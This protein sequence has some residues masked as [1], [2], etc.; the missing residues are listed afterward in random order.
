MTKNCKNS[1][2]FF[3]TNSAFAEQTFHREA[4]SIADKGN[5]RCIPALRKVRRWGILVLMGYIHHG[6][7]V[8]IINT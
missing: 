3:S 5:F 1:S 2:S 8:Y 4:I 7:A 6:R